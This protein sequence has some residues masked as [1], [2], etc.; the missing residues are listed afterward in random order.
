MFCSTFLFVVR[1]RAKEIALFLS[2]KEKA[3]LKWTFQIDLLK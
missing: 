2:F 3:A 1:H